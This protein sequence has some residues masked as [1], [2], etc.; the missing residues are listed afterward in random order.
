M[1]HYKNAALYIMHFHVLV[2]RLERNFHLSQ[3]IQK[4][5]EACIK[6]EHV[7]MQKRVCSQGHL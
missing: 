2:I 7:E 6:A 5:Q 1:Y 4:N 3:G